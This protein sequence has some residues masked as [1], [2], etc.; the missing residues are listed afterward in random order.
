MSATQNLQAFNGNVI[1][2][3]KIIL[4][5][6]LIVLKTN[7]T[8]TKLKTVKFE[9]KSILPE[10]GIEPSTYRFSICRSTSEL[11]THLN[12]YSSLK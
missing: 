6:V 2:V 4:K 12:F 11:P 7:A 1:V 9:I 8:V 3:G 5:V 10:D